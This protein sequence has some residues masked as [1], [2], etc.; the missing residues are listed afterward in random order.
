MVGCG[1]R[2]GGWDQFS[3]APRVCRQ[4][5]TE[6]YLLCPCTTL[7]PVIVS[8][9][10]AGLTCLLLPR[11]LGLLWHCGGV[12][13][14]AAVHIDSS[15]LRSARAPHFLLLCGS[16]FIREPVTTEEAED[17]CEVISNP[18]DFQ[19]MQSKCSCGN[20]R[21]VQE[22]LSDM[23]QVFSNAE[24]YNQNGSHVLSCLEKTEQCLID[25]VH[26]HLP[27]HT[28]ARR[29]RKKF[30]AGCQGLE[31]QEGDS[32]SEPLEHSRGRRRKK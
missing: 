9:P 16:S 17:Y 20:Y 15:A 18:M 28:Y 2:A 31:E 22:F 32:E 14:G 4:C 24:R 1:T 30:S 12:W 11:Y 13:V 5:C 8:V 21:S 19:T 26:K 6:P 25:M 7:L 29:K 23:K 10:T 3:A 27:G